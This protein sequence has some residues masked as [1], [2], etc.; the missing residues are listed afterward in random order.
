MFFSF[1][2][3]EKVGPCGVVAN[4]VKQVRTPI[5]LLRSFSD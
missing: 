4:V 1:N 3:N 2:F 5:L